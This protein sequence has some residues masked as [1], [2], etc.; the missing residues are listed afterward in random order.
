M[1]IGPIGLLLLC[2]FPRV[3]YLHR[4]E[5]R[6]GSKDGAYTAKLVGRISCSQCAQV[7][8]SLTCHRSA[9]GGLLPS[10]RL[11]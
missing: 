3:V 6:D 9:T 7:V 1:T 2:L 10:K 11:F 5:P 4:K 8:A